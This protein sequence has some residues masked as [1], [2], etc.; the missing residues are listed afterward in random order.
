[1]GRDCSGPG[2]A[3]VQCVFWTITQIEDAGDPLRSCA[4]NFAVM[5]K[6]LVM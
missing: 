1:M 4:A 2:R 3:K 5:H 6:V